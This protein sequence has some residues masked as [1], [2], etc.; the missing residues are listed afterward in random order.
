MAEF[1]AL[2]RQFTA[3]LRN[4]E[5]APAPGGMEERRLKI[6][7][8]LFF[9][10]IEGLLAGNFPVIRRIL[11]DATW[12]ALLRELGFARVHAEPMSQGTPFANV[13]LVAD[14]VTPSTACRC[15]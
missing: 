14:R 5:H 13:L 3:Y 4:P 9:N 2:Q 8:E 1:Q 6:Y 15:T 10:N 7:R 12:T 11:D